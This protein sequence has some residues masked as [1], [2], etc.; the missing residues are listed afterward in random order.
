MI[1]FDL[2]CANDHRFEGWFASSEDFERQLDEK[3]LVCPLCGNGEIVRLPPAPHVNTAASRAEERA[4]HKPAAAAPQQY[5]NLGGEMLTKL[6]DYVVR[7]TEDVG[8]AFPE[9]ARKIHYR[10]APERHIRGTA[11]AREIQELREE[12]ID[13]VALPVP[14]HLLNKPH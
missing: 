1:V 5:V 9:E 4:Q 13:V 7:S 3:L 2:S 10:E 11:S 6:I 14:P 8:R 12:G